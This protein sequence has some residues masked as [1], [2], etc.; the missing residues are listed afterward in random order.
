MAKA[1]RSKQ[2]SFDPLAPTEPGHWRLIVDF[3]GPMAKAVQS[4]SERLGINYQATVKTLIDE[5][6]RLRS[7]AKTAKGA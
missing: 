7:Q 6:L 2:E 5:A 1:K 4:E 3:T